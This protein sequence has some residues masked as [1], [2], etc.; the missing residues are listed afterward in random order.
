MLLNSHS[1]DAIS[2]YPN[3]AEDFATI[4]IPNLD[5]ETV[6]VQIFDINGKV[7]AERNYGELT[8]AMNLPINTADFEAGM[9]NVQ[10]LVGDTKTVKKLVVQ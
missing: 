4:N 8:G 2:L 7:V 10:I 6:I 3:P 9:Y 1:P 5:N